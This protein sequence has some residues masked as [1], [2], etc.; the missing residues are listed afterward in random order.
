[1]ET[2]KNGW[3]KI[4]IAVA[5][6]GAAI[7]G[8]LYW[9]QSS[10]GGSEKLDEKAIA[11]E[12]HHLVSTVSATGTINASDKVDIG[13]KISGRILRVYIEENSYV[14]EGDILMELDA[15]Q[16]RSQ[17]AQTQ[18]NLD[19]ANAFY[20]RQKKLFD[21]GAIAAQ[22]L[23][24]AEKTYRVA[25]ASHQSAMSQLNDTIIKA[26]MSG[27]VI[28]KPL[29][30]GSTVSAGTAS[31]MVLATLANLDKMEIETLV[32][33]SDIGQVK[34]GMSATFQVDTF[35]DKTFTGEVVKISK[36]STVSNNV[37]YYKVLIKVDQ[38]D[39]LLPGMTARVTVETE[40]RE[41]VLA[42]PARY[43]RERSGKKVVHVLGTDNKVEPRE[44]V[45]GISTDEHIE[46]VSGLELGEK[47]VLGSSGARPGETNGGSNN[48]RV[49]RRL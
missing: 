4:L 24:D 12:S 7:G 6:I 35:I 47:I 48:L 46:I 30:A 49:P 11:V 21:Q 25:L 18:A 20:G 19:N 14:N 8:W 3:K 29:T 1:V 39:G 44:V 5:V 36:A 37:I 28:G 9:Q 34:E 41:G 43:V 33:E 15:E 22:T 26:P 32:D 2:K 23:D 17:V 40:N 38:P 10:T 16:I 27:F 42:V 45:T 13:S 31:V